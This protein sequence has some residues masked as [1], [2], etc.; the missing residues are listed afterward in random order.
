MA[1]TYR[2]TAELENG[3]TIEQVSDTH[4]PVTTPPRQVPK[5]V[6]AGYALSEYRANA[7]YSGTVPRRKVLWVE[8]AEEPE[9]ARD[10]YFVRVLA[11]APDPL[12]LPNAGPAPE[13]A[14]YE[15]SSLDPE[16]VRV[17]SPGQADD[18]GGLA[19]M[20]PLARAQGGGRHFLVPLPPDTSPE[21]PELFGFYTYE[22]RLGHDRGTPAN[23]FWSTAQGRFG[24]E[25]VLNGVQ[26]PSAPIAC[27]IVRDRDSIVVTA[28]Y[29]QPFYRGQSVAPRRPKTQVWIVLYAQVMQV[30]GATNRNIQLDVHPA[31]PQE[32]KRE[33]GTVRPRHI[34]GEAIWRQSDVE[35][36]LRAYGLPADS[37]LSV[38]AV[39]L[40]PE[41]NGR[42]PDPLGGDL[43]EVRI[44]R[45]SP[46]HP[47]RD[48][49]CA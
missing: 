5:V 19:S 12:L 45:T 46:L 22:I 3:D 44:L 49:C 28:E 9:D 26:H 10:R 25:L 35:R 30:D 8:F 27:F 11:H 40:L 17:V 13:P 33:P 32:R 18:F 37:R 21:S 1:V 39:E 14:G 34:A 29:A 4:L 2:V 15:K 42:F 47:L 23:P 24:P 38:L 7:G 41:P 43:G 48:T 36:L 6:A 20:Q 31:L 16:T